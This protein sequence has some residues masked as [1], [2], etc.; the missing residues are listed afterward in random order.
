MME[1]QQPIA[2]AAATTTAIAAHADDGENLSPKNMEKISENT[3]TNEGGETNSDTLIAQSQEIQRPHQ[4]MLL[5]AQ[6]QE[7][8]RPHQEMLLIAQSQEMPPSVFAETPPIPEEALLLSLDHSSSSSAELKLENNTPDIGNDQLEYALEEVAPAL[9]PPQP[10]PILVKEQL[11]W[12]K[13]TIA[14]LKKR[15][16]ASI[17]LFPVNPVALNI[18]HYFDVG[19]PGRSC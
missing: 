6:S 7:I 3:I 2:K 9:L 14:N 18:P 10:D 1:L 4:E 8:Q 13:K 12:L 5:I 17:F 16:D 11:N 19:A 15:K